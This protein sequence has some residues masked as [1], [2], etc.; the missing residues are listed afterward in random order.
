[1][2]FSAQTRFIQIYRNTVVGKDIE[3]V[4][5]MEEIAL[6]LSEREVSI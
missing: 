5:R 6:R 2:S 1:M 3:E 4:K